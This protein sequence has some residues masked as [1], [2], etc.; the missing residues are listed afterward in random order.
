MTNSIGVPDG[1]RLCLDLTWPYYTLKQDT[2]SNRDTGVKCILASDSPWWIELCM[3]PL[4]KLEIRS[5]QQTFLLMPRFGGILYSPCHGSNSNPARRKLVKPLRQSW[6]ILPSV[7]CKMDTPSI[8][9]Y[10]FLLLPVYSMFMF[11]VKIIT[12]T[13]SDNVRAQLDS[14]WNEI[15]R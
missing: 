13:I 14:T 15:T 11:R 2:H 8:S 5:G 9:K 6:A 7:P 4:S 10:Y 1:F 3:E 12:Y